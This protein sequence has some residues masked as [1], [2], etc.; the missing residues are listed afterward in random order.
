M[1]VLLV[2]R[3]V[4]EG[5]KSEPVHPAAVKDAEYIAPDHSASTEGR[6]LA[7][8]PSDHWH[9]CPDRENRRDHHAEPDDY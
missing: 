2:H 9:Q 5:R 6:I 8:R 1:S 7:N 3:I 4:P